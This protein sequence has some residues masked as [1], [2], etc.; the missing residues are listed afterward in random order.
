LI[1]YIDDITL[2]G[3]DEGR[4]A[5]DLDFWKSIFISQD[6]QK[7]PSKIQM[8]S[9]SVKFPGESKWGVVKCPFLGEG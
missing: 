6:E 1:H 5:A 9:T 2:I 8:D 4:L 7:N 3:P